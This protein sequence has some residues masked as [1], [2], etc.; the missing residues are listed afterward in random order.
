MKT[1]KNPLHSATHMLEQHQAFQAWSQTR[2]PLWHQKWLGSSRA[3]VLTGGLMGLTCLAGVGLM[4]LG[5]NSR[6][7]VLSGLGFTLLMLSAGA[8]MSPAPDGFMLN[9]V[10]N[11]MLSRHSKEHGVLFQTEQA[12]ILWGAYPQGKKTLLLSNMAQLDESWAPIKA[13]VLSLINTSDLPYVW[14]QQMEYEVALGLKQQHEAT[15]QQRQEN[16]FIQAQTQVQSQI[17]AALDVTVENEWGPEQNTR[18]EKASN[19][20]L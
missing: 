14:W 20:L 7:A 9:N 15:A 2:F 10:C 3:G 5:F 17:Q 19:I 6:S 16:E 13:E 18:G 12:H 8:F 11:E 4:V 1:F